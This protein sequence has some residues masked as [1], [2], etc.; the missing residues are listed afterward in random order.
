MQ[1]REELKENLASVNL[2][3]TAKYKFLGASLIILQN[4]EKLQKRTQQKEAFNKWR[5]SQSV[6]R[7][8]EKAF[9]KILELNHR[10]SN[11]RFESACFLL[12]K[13]VGKI[14]KKD[15]FG[16][17]SQYATMTQLRH[18]RQRNYAGSSFVTSVHQS[19]HPMYYD[20]R[21]SGDKLSNIVR[22][23]I[24]QHSGSTSLQNPNPSVP[25][26]ISLSA[27][28]ND[29]SHLGQHRPSGFASFMTPNTTTS[30]QYDTQIANFGVQM[31]FG[32]VPG[33]ITASQGSK[34]R[35]RSNSRSAS[36]RRSLVQ[37]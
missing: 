3:R 26:H 14:I 29:S 16:H 31:G 7:I 30:R 36:Q 8:A 5:F 6:S 19:P 25:Q 1:E 4:M 23:G 22:P 18:H 17:I 21:K 13:S 35:R 9:N 2:D 11:Q 28:A 24:Q 32:A 37:R 15:A 27:N 33:R 34:K 12:T 10:H 20:S